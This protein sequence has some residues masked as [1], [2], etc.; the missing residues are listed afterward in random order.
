MKRLLATTLVLSLCS[1]GG[2]VGRAT[3]AGAP[4]VTTGTAHSVT[5]TSATVTGTVNPNGLSTTFS[6]Q[7][8]T[9]TGY[10]FQTSAKSIGSGDTAQ[11]VSGTL[12]GLRPGTTY[13][14]RV[15]ATN[16]SGTTVGGDQTFTTSGSPP[17][18]ASP[19]TVT[20][21][22]T[23]G[24][25]RHEA[26]LRGTVNPNGSKTT[27]RFEF[28]LTPSYGTQSAPKS[29][30]AGSTAR[31]VSARLTA[32]QSGQT[33]H[34]RL[35]ASNAGGVSLGQDRTFST[36]TAT[37]GRSVP[38]ITSRVTPAI[39]RRRPFRFK[40]RG[41]LIRPPGV[42]RS[43]GCRGRVT[44]RFKAGRKTVRL[45]RTRVRSSCRYRARVR[46]SLRRHPRT[47]RVFVRFRGNAVLKPQSAPVRRVR[48]G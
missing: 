7:F 35:V 47:L 32:L 40:V 11:D 38:A 33:Y 42:S 3:A 15:I 9:T 6:F 4:I 27:Y 16:A 34:Y 48:A 13:H 37:G 5:T 25:G 43:R 20:T 14:F 45:R 2:L 28:G 12:T 19:A 8:G 44:I 10:G 23:T 30:S 29:L 39:D 1:I 24:V 36:S 18:P 26:T 31:S 41:K 17:A 22:A 21:G 46:V